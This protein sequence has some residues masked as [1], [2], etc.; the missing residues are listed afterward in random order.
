MS[1]ICTQIFAFVTTFVTVYLLEIALLE[2]ILYIL[3]YIKFQSVYF[4]LL[5]KS[6]V[7]VKTYTFLLK[8]D[9]C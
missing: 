8:K 2:N 7:F 5:N 6:F 1:Y 9:V 4:I 3:K